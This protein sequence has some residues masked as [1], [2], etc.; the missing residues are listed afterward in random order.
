MGSL[1]VGILWLLVMLYI[2]LFCQHRVCEAYFVP[3]LNVLMDQM[4]SSSN[5]WLQRL[6][7]PGVA[8][9]TFM[10][11][12]ANGPELFTNLFSIFAGSDSGIGVVIGSEIFNLLVIIG[13]STCASKVSPLYLEKVPFVRDV[14]YYAFSIALLLWALADA[15]I[16]MFECGV[17]LLA[18]VSYWTAVYFT[19]DIAAKILGPAEEAGSGAKSAGAR[20]RGVEVDVEII[21]HS[22]MADG[23]GH[24]TQEG[25]HMEATEFGIVAPE[26]QEEQQPGQ[27]GS[28]GFTLMNDQTLKYADLS[29]VLVVGEGVL[30]MT[31]NKGLLGEV[32]FK[33]KADNSQQRDLLLQNLKD[34][35][36]SNKIAAS[37]WIHKYD[38][39]PSGSIEN[40]KHHFASGSALGKL[41]AILEFFIDIALC[42][43]LSWCLHLHAV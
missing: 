2:M 6:G 27:R 28:V 37:T 31:F 23:H 20:I 34:N 8:G 3:A 19:E 14:C 21:Y 30:I 33:C 18:G 17:M 1:V 4:G 9:A 38:P 7:N 39:S 42:S 22:R 25:V 24:D 40:F 32:S 12:G 10:A 26:M 43:T 29:E 15:Y 35:A 36:Q 16:D 5:P 41:H 11:L 13:A